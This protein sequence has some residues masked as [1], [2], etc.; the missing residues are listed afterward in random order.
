MEE[1]E[2]ITWKATASPPGARAVARPAQGGS[3]IVPAAS[4][5]RTYRETE[6]TGRWAALL[7]MK[8]LRFHRL[9][10]E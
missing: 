2:V 9:S 8:E 10:A 3:A 7:Q 4:C 6:E 1:A 5:S